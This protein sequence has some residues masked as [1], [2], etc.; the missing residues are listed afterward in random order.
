M[1][2]QKIIILG[3]EYSLE[4][5]PNWSRENDASGSCC[6]NTMRI[7]I[8]SSHPDS[9]QRSTLIHE[10]LEAIDFE[11]EIKLEHSQITRLETGLFQ[12]LTQN[13]ELINLLALKKEKD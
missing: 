10:L 6:C 3:H 13:P 7:V 2:K 12:V 9:R 1:E 8:D 5:D 4:Y 11:L